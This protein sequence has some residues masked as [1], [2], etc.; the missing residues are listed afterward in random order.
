MIEVNLQLDDNCI[1]KSSDFYVTA[2]YTNKNDDYRF[3]QKKC[4]VPINFLIRTCTPENVASL[5]VT[6][7]STGSSS[8]HINQ[9]FPGKKLFASE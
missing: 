1:P 5:N 4:Q 8:L 6:I 3:V 9:I 2:T 7:K